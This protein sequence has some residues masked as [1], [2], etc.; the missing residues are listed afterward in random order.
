MSPKEMLEHVRRHARL[1]AAGTRTAPER[2]RSMDAAINWSYGLLTDQEQ[3]L[4]RR[5]SVFAGTF[6][7]ESAEAVCA[8]PDKD[9]SAIAP[10]LGALIEKSLITADQRPAGRTR[11]RLLEVIRYYAARR[12]DESDEAE[13]IKRRHLSHFLEMAE[14]EAPLLFVDPRAPLQRL[15]AERDNLRLALQWAAEN[16]SE[17]ELRLALSLWPYWNSHSHLAE[18]RSA[19]EHA[20]ATD[21]GDPALRGAA[22][23]RAGQFAWYSGDYRA[24]ERYARESIKLLRSVQ[25]GAAGLTV[26][27]WLLGVCML[28]RRAF[29]EAI[30]LF[31]ESVKA[32][33]ATGQH[34]FP[35]PA[36]SALYVIKMQ[37]GDVANAR[38][39]AA[40]LLVEFSEARYPLQHC[41][42]TSAIAIEEANLGDWDRVVEALK[43]SL[44]VA[45]EY[46]FWYWG[47]VAVRAAAYLAAATRNHEECLRLVG[48]SQMLRGGVPYSSWTTSKAEQLL[49]RARAALSTEA[50]RALIA[51]GEKMTPDSAF[52]MAVSQLQTAQ[53][54]M[55]VGRDGD[56]R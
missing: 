34:L 41:I 51:E 25:G 47:G 36:L 39:M 37:T 55:A 20:L 29:K 14:R 9:G 2:Q 32:A 7:L 31:E 54:L 12:L 44:R 45:Q 46:R 13:Q 53:T 49:E 35:L 21:A 26:G 1:L 48:A 43:V 23:A 30:P 52:A 4:F 18:G 11:Y 3:A 56:R 33:A 24:A 19:L 5:L 28:K 38:H 15:D 42:A 10:L 50:T 22:I 16:D 8:S 17:L 27:L 40:N 6:S